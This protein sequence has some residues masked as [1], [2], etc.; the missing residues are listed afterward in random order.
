VTIAALPR[1][2]H[3]PDRPSPLRSSLAVPSSESQI[4]KGSP[5]MSLN[6]HFPTK[7]LDVKLE[8]RAEAVIGARA[9]RIFAIN[10]AIRMGFTFI[11]DSSGPP[12]ADEN[13]PIRAHV[14][15][16]WEPGPFASDVSCWHLEPGF[17]GVGLGKRLHREAPTLK[18]L[19]GSSAIWPSG[20]A[21]ELA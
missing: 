21:A 12:L 7:P 2:F 13:A 6:V 18:A 17:H 1:G 5:L 20:S 14:L 10:R 11:L 19:I 3:M 9:G 15:A 4:V 8:A 16:R